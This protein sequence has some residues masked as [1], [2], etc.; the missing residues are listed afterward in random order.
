MT[1]ALGVTFFVTVL[2]G[3]EARS[4][5]GRSPFEAFD[6][7]QGCSKGGL[8][9][10]EG[11]VNDSDLTG[12][13]SGGALD[14]MFMNDMGLAALSRLGSSTSRGVVNSLSAIDCG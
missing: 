4:G 2:G 9:W 11:V 7:R 13:G 12:S 10:S 3:V 6:D 5:A 1:G 14:R 8:C